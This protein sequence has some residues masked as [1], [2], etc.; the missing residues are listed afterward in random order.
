MGDSTHHVDIKIDNRKKTNQKEDRK[1][2]IRKKTDM[3]RP[4]KKVTQNT[5]I[6]TRSRRQQ[7]VQFLIGCLG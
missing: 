5:G 1:D 6:A 7:G 2:P 4:P 3:R